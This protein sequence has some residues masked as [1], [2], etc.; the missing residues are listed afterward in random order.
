MQRAA[1][2]LIYQT[3]F[4]KE[5]HEVQAQ[6]AHTSFYQQLGLQLISGISSQRRFVDLGEKLVG[7]AEQAYAFRQL[8]QLA[9][10]TR[11]LQGLP[12]PRQYQ[13][14]A[15]YFRG[16]ELM[17]RGDL[18]G[19]KPVLE[20]IAAEPPHR[21]S[22]R[23]IQS[24]GAVFKIQGD[25]DTSLKLHIEAGRCAAGK[26]YNDLLTVLFVR[27][28]IAVLKSMDGDHHGALVDLQHMEPAMKAV[29][30]IH[31]PV[32]YD[33]LNSLAVELGEIG[34]LEEA[35]RASRIV[36]STPFVVA[37][38]EW[39]ETFDEI[40][41]KKRRASHS[42]VVVREH[43]GTRTVEDCAA[44]NRNLVRLHS[45]QRIKN[46]PQMDK[47][48]R[49]TRARVLN[50]Q[51]WKTMFNTSN[52]VSPLEVASGLRGRMTTGEKLIRLMDL[53]SQDQTDDETIDRILETVEK[54]VLKRQS[55][56]LD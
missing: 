50:F 39:R 22:A 15:R 34:R 44:Q 17:R 21:Y 49:G 4:S 23:A 13:T 11:A 40:A 16:L 46:A 12:L 5:F 36:V 37:Y 48:T 53:I 51:E 10:L 31:R 9:E 27:K 41:I 2:N 14:A 38:P 55:Q 20:S 24:L 52:R 28:N 1:N 47:R 42:A 56:N 25:L 43:A 26:Q 29:G 54:I 7:L 18:D 6:L 33:Y 35:A 19:A 45:A 30:L 32:Y 8:D 3:S